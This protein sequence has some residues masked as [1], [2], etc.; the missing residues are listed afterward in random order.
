MHRLLP[1]LSAGLLGL[2]ACTSGSQCKLIEDHGQ[3]AASWAATAQMI[4]KHWTA[5][6]LPTPYVRTTLSQGEQQVRRAA[7]KL[8]SATE[9]DAAAAPAVAAYQRLADVLQKMRQAV[10]HGDRRAAKA[11]ASA[12]PQIQKQIGD[13]RSRCQ[14][15]GER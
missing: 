11:L 13:S 8:A 9:R 14:S 6:D 1:L 10:G 15:E 3:S 4:S 2:G 12:L 7:D 5:S